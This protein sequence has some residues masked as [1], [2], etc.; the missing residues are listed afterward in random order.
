[1]SAVANY[2]TARPRGVEA[3]DAEGNVLLL[4]TPD[5]T[6]EAWAAY[7]VWRKTPGANHVPLPPLAAPAPPL[8]DE[9]ITARLALAVQQH[10][11]DTAR[12]RNY[13][14][15]KSAALRASYV[16][17]WRA[18]GIAFAQWMDACWETAYQV[19][20]DVANG[21]RTTPTASEL[22]A[23]LPTLELPA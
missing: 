18:E 8:T 5:K 13:D 7:T 6:P 16:G 3:L 4:V 23:E 21:L 20:A 15:I 19:Q 10:L 11:D 14:N 17:P 9:E 12:Q 1:M 2:R 22:I